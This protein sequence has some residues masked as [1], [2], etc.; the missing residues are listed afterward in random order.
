MNCVGSKC[1]P[2]VSPVHVHVFRHQ[3]VTG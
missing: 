1:V 2:R 3:Y